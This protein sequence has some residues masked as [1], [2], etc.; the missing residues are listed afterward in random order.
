MVHIKVF[1]YVHVWMYEHYAHMHTDH[2]P[3]CTAG[4][5]PVQQVLEWTPAEQDIP[6]AL[7]T[8]SYTEQPAGKCV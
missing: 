3:R 4:I 6:V 8:D 1:K 7:Q 5:S 2:G